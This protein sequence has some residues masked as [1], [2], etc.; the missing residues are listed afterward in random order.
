MSSTRLN[1]VFAT[2]LCS[3]AACALLVAC[4]DDTSSGDAG[5]DTDADT[6]TDTDTDTDS[7][8]D[9]DADGGAD[10]GACA[11]DTIAAF[12]T[13]PECDACINENCC[14]EAEAAAADPSIIPDLEGCI[15]TTMAGVC[16]PECMTA[17]CDSGGAVT[18]NQQCGQCSS[19]NCCETWKAFLDDALADECMAS[20]DMDFC[21]AV[22]TY[23]AHSDCVRTNCD[24]LPLCNPDC[25]A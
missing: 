25:P 1:S 21:C 9:T 7:D 17:I 6:D 13:T 12:G 14:A 15:G 11:V 19:D 3:L 24:D 5:T 4:G 20:W 16:I 23:S 8:T 2:L 22:E 18:L 10:G